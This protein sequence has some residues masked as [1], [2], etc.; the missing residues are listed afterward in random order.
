[1]KWTVQLANAL[2]NIYIPFD[3]EIFIQYSSME[4]E[5][6]IVI[7]FIKRIRDFYLGDL[8][9]SNILITSDLDIKVAGV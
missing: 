7:F 9:C 5:S 6:F 3:F 1:M 2:G 8:R 4:L